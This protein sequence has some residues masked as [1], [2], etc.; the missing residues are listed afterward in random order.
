MALDSY[1]FRYDLNPDGTIADVRYYDAQGNIH[2]Q[3]ATAFFQGLWGW[4]NSRL[5]LL[6]GI[7]P[8]YNPTTVTGTVG[9]GVSPPTGP[10]PF[11]SVS[12]VLNIGA[13]AYPAGNGSGGVRDPG[14]GGRQL[15]PHGLELHR[16]RPRL[17]RGLRRG[18][19]HQPHDSERVFCREHRQRVQGFREELLPAHQDHAD[20]FPHA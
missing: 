14:L 18:W 15:R 19:P 1:V 20:D 11:A 17:S 2:V 16:R 6:S 9:R 4:N 3:P 10:G 8:Q 7:G 13:N 5:P 12:G